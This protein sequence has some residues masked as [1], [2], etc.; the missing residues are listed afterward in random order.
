MRVCPNWEII[1][2]DPVNLDEPPMIRQYYEWV[3]GEE[4]KHS[5]CP[6]M[7]ESRHSQIWF[8]TVECSCSA[9]ALQLGED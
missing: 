6:L 5:E 2:T 4:I 8:R 7:A 1:F 3:P 9:T